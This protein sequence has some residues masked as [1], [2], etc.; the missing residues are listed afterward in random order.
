MQFVIVFGT[1]KFKFHFN[2]LDMPFFVRARDDRCAPDVQ[3][4]HSRPDPQRHQQARAQCP[5]E[6]R[7]RIRA[8]ASS[9]EDCH[10]SA[11]CV[12]RARSESRIALTTTSRGRDGVAIGFRCFGGEISTPASL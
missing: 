9:A 3:L 11:P 2:F 4:A 1:F 6:S 8:D 5:E 12:M 7:Y 10:V